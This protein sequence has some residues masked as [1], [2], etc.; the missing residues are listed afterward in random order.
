MAAAVT[1]LYDLC[2]AVLEAVNAEWPAEAE[3]LPDLQYVTNGEVAM[4]GCDVLAVSIERTFPIAGDQS[5]E[6]LE[7][8]ISLAQRAAVV[9]LSLFRCVPIVTDDGEEAVN[10]T[11]AQLEESALELLMDAQ[12]LENAVVAA[13]EDERIGGC[14]GVTLAD[15]NALGPFGGMGGCELRIRVRMV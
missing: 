10:P 7:P 4:D 6:V 14:A 12:A 2:Q 13:G 15:S 1:R 8:G 11:A 5:F 9:V 3:P